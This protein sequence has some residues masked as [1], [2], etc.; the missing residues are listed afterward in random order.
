MRAAS[1]SVEAW[2]LLHLWRSL[3]GWGGQLP[4][5]QEHQQISTA[6]SYNSH[7]TLSDTCQIDLQSLLT[8]G[9]FNT[10]LSKQN[11]SR[12]SN[13]SGESLISTDRCVVVELISTIPSLGSTGSQH[14][15]QFWCNIILYLGNTSMVISNRYFLIVSL[16]S[17]PEFLVCLTS[18]NKIEK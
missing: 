8:L 4:A 10:N 9:T 6:V 16:I 12:V 13:K 1:W 15:F 11:H 2:T 5:W 7:Y 17:L 14:Q 3:S 18:V